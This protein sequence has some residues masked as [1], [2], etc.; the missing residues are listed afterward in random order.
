MSILQ[1]GEFPDPA[2]ANADTPSIQLLRRI[3]RLRSLCASTPKRLLS[4]ISA[5]TRS[6]ADFN[7]T[8]RISE[9]VDDALRA[10]QAVARGLQTGCGSSPVRIRWP[11]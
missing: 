7:R 5:A 11:R 9:R 4:F 3:R 6:E 8:L 10:G 2:G 1:N